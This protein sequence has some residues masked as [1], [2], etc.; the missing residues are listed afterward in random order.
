MHGAELAG[1]SDLIVRQR[2]YSASV[3]ISAPLFGTLANKAIILIETKCIRW[4]RPTLSQ[5]GQNMEPQESKPPS[6]I[7]SIDIDDLF[8]QFQYRL[9]SAASLRGDNQLLLLYGDNGAGKS[10]ILN[11]V[12]HLL[13]PAPYENHRSA[14][15]PVP[16]RSVKIILTS[17]H[18][19]IAEKDDPFDQSQYRLRLHQ[20][21]S[22]AVIEHVWEYERRG[23]DHTDLAY[24]EYC[25]TLEEIGL[26]FHFLSDTRR[27][28]GISE[29]S[30]QEFPVQAIHARAHREWYSVLR[31]RSRTTTDSEVQVGE[32]VNRTIEG[33]RRLAL[34]GTS[35]GYTSVNTIYEE[36]I[37][38]IVEPDHNAEESHLLPISELIRNLAALRKRNFDYAKYG[39]TPDLNT[40]RLLDLLD[41]AQDPSI[42]ILNTVLK[43]Y[44]DGHH[45]RLSALE[46]AQKV[47]DEFA[48]MLSEFFSH[49]I[50]QL[51]VSTGLEILDRKKKRIPP[52]SLSSGERQLVVLFCNA[53]T[54]R[55]DGTIL[56]IDE[57]EISLNVKW[58]R[59]LISALL[60]CLEDVH[61]QIIL[62]TH[63]IEILSQ[64][65]EYV[66]TL[67]DL[68]GETDD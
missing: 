68:S 5:Q 6:L 35:A 16:F 11:I 19:V 13:H 53:I 12:F 55:K 48:T 50:V 36:L 56:V 24:N 3:Y 39:L 57:P 29:H 46:P 14:V 1:T 33:L 62:A 42:E 67:S 26:S 41:R 64:Y 2:R 8:G 17:G 38:R 20:P 28:E 45:A 40:D 43:P 44:F 15:G 23:K 9:R 49:K 27:A 65:N 52:E 34:T 30:S 63:S 18:T 7:Q 51:D 59:R 4:T 61:T 32:A 47:I 10:T 58:Q 31:K 60:S 54:A 21:D 22:D 25:Q 66:V 37:S